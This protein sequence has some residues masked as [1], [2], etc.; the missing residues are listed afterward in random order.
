MRRVKIF[1]AI[2]L[3]PTVDYYYYY[4]PFHI[5]GSIYRLIYA[6]YCG[7]QNI[8]YGDMSAHYSHRQYYKNITVSKEIYIVTE[9]LLY[10]FKQYKQ[11]HINMFK[12]DIFNG[13]RV[14][15]NSSAN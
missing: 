13:E 7:A 6:C 12:C 11:T 3:T 5:I 2:L 4:Y 15:N 10:I 14:I 9:V 8:C 1:Y